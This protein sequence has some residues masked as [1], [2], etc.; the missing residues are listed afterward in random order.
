MGLIRG[1]GKLTG[2][3]VTTVGVVGTATGGI[4]LGLSANNTY[5]INVVGG[6][7]TLGVGFNNWGKVL[8]AT[9]PSGNPMNVTTPQN[10]WTK[11]FEAKKIDSYQSF[12]TTLG[13][14][15]SLD[16]VNNLE[17]LFDEKPQSL[18]HAISQAYA[19]YVGGIVLLVVLGLALIIGILLIAVTK[20][21][22][23]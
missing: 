9:G 20:K 15:N 21:K 23:S 12:A 16:N 4:L 11:V 13:V 1:L 10:R 3:I 18:S 8:K 5:T 19:M 2:I 17:Q 6:T 7:E 14:S 22:K